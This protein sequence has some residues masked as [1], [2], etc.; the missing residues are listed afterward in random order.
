[1]ETINKDYI[2]QVISDEIDE[3]Y[4]ELS[5]TTSDSIYK[6]YHSAIR[7]LLKV[8]VKLEADPFIIVRLQYLKE[9]T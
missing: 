5:N 6:Y 9:R 8:A 1:M 7:S 4:D 3:I 2:N